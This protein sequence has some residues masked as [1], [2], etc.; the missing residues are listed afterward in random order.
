MSDNSN[1][2]DGFLARL[3]KRL[4]LAPRLMLDG[5]VPLLLKLAPL[6]AVIY[7]IL[8]DPFFGPLDDLLVTVLAF[9]LFVELCPPDV[10]AEQARRAAEELS[11]VQRDPRTGAPVVDGQ[12]RDVTEE[13]EVKDDP[14]P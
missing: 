6:A 10:V 12:Y 11:G 13:T 1:P 8:P 4:Q 3:G 9:I 2:Q 7:F 5:R 14:K